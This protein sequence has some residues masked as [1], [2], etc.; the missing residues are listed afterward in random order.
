MHSPPQAALTSLEDYHAATRQFAAAFRATDGEQLEA[1]LS[2]LIGDPLAE[3]CVDLRASLATD[4]DR[5][6]VRGFLEIGFFAAVERER[7]LVWWMFNFD[8]GAAYANIAMEVQCEPYRITDP[9]FQGAPDLFHW[10]R[11]RVEGDGEATGSPDNELIDERATRAIHD[12]EVVALS[13]GFG[14]IAGSLAPDIPSWGRNTFPA[15]PRFV[16]LDPTF[17]TLSQPL[18]RL[19]EAAI[20]PANPAWMKTLALFPGESTYAEYALE[21]GDPKTDMDVYRDYKIRHIRRLE[22][23]ATRREANYLS[24]MIEELPRA[25][26]SNGLMVGTRAPK[27]ERLCRKQCSSISTSPSTFIVALIGRPG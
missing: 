22:V 10:I 19:E 15:A 18:M 23:R 26:E 2:E 11:R 9:L 21:E 24:M 4:A 7:R 14:R 3:V 6:G 27:P 17:W 25:D 13:R 20:A 12:S 8:V 16:R 5:E 1:F